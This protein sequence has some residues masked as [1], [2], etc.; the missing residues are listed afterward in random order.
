MTRPVHRSA[1][2]GAVCVLMALLLALPVRTGAQ[3][4]QADGAQNRFAQMTDAAFLRMLADL[5]A[6][7]IAPRQFAAGDA[8]CGFDLT[9]ETLRRARSMSATDRAAMMRSMEPRTTDTSILSPSGFFRVN[10][11][12]SGPNAPALLVG[13][14]AARIPGTAVQYA[15]KIAEFFDTAYDVEVTQQGYMSPPFETGMQ[16]YQIFI[17]D[18]NGQ[19]YG[20]TEWTEER[21]IGSVKP[22][23]ATYITVDNDFREFF[24]KGLKGASVTAAHEFHH[25]LQLGGYGW[26]ENDTFIYEITSTFFEDEVFPGVDDYFQYL[27]DF[28]PLPDMSLY[29]WRGYE[30]VLWAKC[31]TARHGRAVLRRTW[32]RMRSVQPMTA[33][34]NA[35]TEV[36]SGLD[37]EYCVFTRWNWYTRDRASQTTTERYD[38]ADQIREQVRVLATLGLPAKFSNSIPAMGSQYCRVVRGVDT[39]VFA[40][41]NINMSMSLSKASMEIGYELEVAGSQI[42]ASWV[43]AGNGLWYKLTPGMENTFC[44]SVFTRGFIPD[45]GFVGAYPNPFNPLA[46]GALRFSLSKSITVPRARLAIYSAGM[47]LLFENGQ[48]GIVR[49]PVMGTY[50]EWN[51]RTTGGDMPAS[52]MYIFAIE[53]G[54]EMITGKFAII[55]K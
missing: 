41:A 50:V 28:F 45:K 3:Q 6:P 48:A 35:L 30:A 8:K 37:Q 18:Y 51:G 29:A 42:D 54:D 55:K 31:I 33:M 15:Q 13:D 49:D 39:V 20:V 46:E 1:A 12:L 14:T 5:H 10:F 43:E 24:T 2:A 53:A 27:K 36:Q 19:Y 34:Q 40:V 7:Q 4:M 52:G 26:W 23:F 44:V 9:T 32:E 21:P 22:T 11:D 17:R 25:A 16:E 47:D 38:N